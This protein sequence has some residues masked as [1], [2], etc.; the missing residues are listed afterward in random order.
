MGPRRAVQPA[1]GHTVIGAAFQKIL[2]LEMAARP[3]GAGDRVHGQRLAGPIHRVQI[4]E[5]RMQ[6]VEAAEVEHAAVL[7]R[8]RRHEF[9]AQVGQRRVPVRHD[10]GQ[11]IERAAQ[12][13]HDK[14]PVGRRI[15][16]RQGSATEGECRCETE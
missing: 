3:I 4:G 10:R 12:V 9:A 15:R 2:R 16:Q 6:T 7:A 13:D 1:A 14:S 8:R 5:C 11:S